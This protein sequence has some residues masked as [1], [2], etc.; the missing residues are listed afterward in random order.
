MRSRWRTWALPLAA[1]AGLMAGCRSGNEEPSSTSHATSG[2]AAETSPSRSEVDKVAADA[3]RTTDETRKEL[4]R[5][6]AEAGKEAERAAPGSTPSAAEPKAPMA[7]GTPMAKIGELAPDFELVD[8]DGKKHSLSAY[9]GK[10][11]V[12]E[13]FSPG[14]P[15]CKYA[16]SK[17]PFTTMPERYVKEGMV[18]LSVNSEAP[19]N[20]AATPDMN[21]KFVETYKMQVPIVFDPKGIV[22]RSYGAKSTPHMFVID[23]KGVL[24]YKGAIDNAPNGQVPKGKTLVNYV[25]AAIADQKAGRKVSE[26]ET[27]SYG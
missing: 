17:G 10:F 5:K 3:Q 14:C 21:R 8:L 7:D 9:R 24:V 26:P 16:Y 27:T 22:G 6:V 4:D 25:D 13:W 23:P 18:W 11:V 19:E 20:D 2:A 12:L 15:A 1:T